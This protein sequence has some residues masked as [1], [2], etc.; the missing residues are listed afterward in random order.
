[1]LPDTDGRSEAKKQNSYR[2]TSCPAPPHP[3]SLYPAP[4]LHLT[5]PVFN[6]VTPTTHSPNAS[7][8]SGDTK[9]RNNRLS[10]VQAR[11]GRGGV[12]RGGGAG[13]GGVGWVRGTMEQMISY[14]LG[15]PVSVC[16]CVQLPNLE[17]VTTLQLYSPNFMCEWH[18]L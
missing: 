1:M 4:C 11:G 6:P 15:T 2:I 3:A 7:V 16:V 5:E 8:A 13:L 10:E 18:L 17:H 9:R 12:A 14:T